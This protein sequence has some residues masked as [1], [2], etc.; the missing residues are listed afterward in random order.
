L[1]FRPLGTEHPFRE[2]FA[3]NPGVL[4]ENRGCRVFVVSADS[5]DESPVIFACLACL[6]LVRQPMLKGLKRLL[7]IEI[8]IHHLDTLRF[9]IGD[10]KL[11]AA[12]LARTNDAIVGE[13]VATLTFHTL[14]KGVAVHVSAELRVEG[15][16]LLRET[17]DTESCYFQSY[18]EV[19]RHFLESVIRIN[20]FE[21]DASDNLKTLAL[22]EE[23][24]A[25]SGFEMDQKVN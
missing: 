22:V 4:R 24:Y 12:R 16:M 15:A 5:F 9:L 17:F 18:T 11:M 7:V 6:A 25:I 20:L 13:D 1:K 10:M 19:I 23:S 2:V 3:E 8:L 14:E 21:T